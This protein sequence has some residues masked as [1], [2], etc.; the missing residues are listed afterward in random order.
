MGAVTL[1]MPSTAI[2]GEDVPISGSNTD[3]FTTYL[4]LTGPCNPV[5]GANLTDPATP[6]TNGVGSTFTWL[7]VTN[8]D[9][10][11]IYNAMHNGWVTSDLKIQ[12]GVYTIYATSKPVD[13]CHL[14][15]CVAYTSRVITLLEPTIEA[16]I[17]PNPY[18]RDCCSPSDCVIIKGNTTGNELHQIE[19]WILSTENRR[20]ALLSWLCRGLLWRF[21]NKSL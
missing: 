6:V 12:P 8:Y 1:E 10:T 5:C 7:N 3:S 16:T 11:W 20:Q 18:I 15:G 13:A 17:S 4:Y 14:P 19:Y 9:R 21:R 2:L